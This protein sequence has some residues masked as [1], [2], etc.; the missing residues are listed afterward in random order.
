MPILKIKTENGTWQDISTASEHA[1]TMNDITDLPASIV[2][3]VEALKDKVGSDS[4]A[5]QVDA[6]LKTIEW[7]TYIHPS[8]HP[9]DMIE[10]LADV[11]TSG[12]YN[13]LTDK[14]SIEGLAT[15]EYVDESIEGLATKEYVDEKVASSG[16]MVEQ[17][18][19]DW[20]ETDVNS[21]AYIKNKPVISGGGSTSVQANWNQMDI[22]QADYI[23]NKPFGESE[24][25][26]DILPTKRYDNFFLNSDFGAFMQQE[27][28]NYEFVV[29]DTYTVIWDNEEYTCI[30]QDVNA[31]L[32]GAIAI[33]NCAL[34]DATGALGL[35]GNNEPFIIAITQDGHGIYVSTRDTS[36]GGSH[37]VCI[38]QKTTTIKQIDKKYLPDD[39]GMN[40]DWLQNDFAQSDYIKNRP[41]Y[42]YDGVAEILP[43]NDFAPFVFDDS[44]GAGL[45]MFHVN[46]EHFSP[47]HTITLGQL[48]TV[49]WDGTPYK[50]VAQDASQLEDGAIGLGNCSML[51][52]YGNNEPFAIA[53]LNGQGA[54]LFAFTDQVEGNSHNVQI[55]RTEK[56]IV[57]E[58]NACFQYD[59]TIERNMTTIPV[60]EDVYKFWSNGDWDEVIVYWDGIEYTCP[61][62][63]AEGVVSDRVGCGDVGYLLGNA[64]AVGAPPFAAYMV[65]N[66]N[67]NGMTVNSIVIVSTIEDVPASEPFY[68][69]VSIYQKS[70]TCKPIE[71]KFLSN[72]PWEKITP[73][74]FGTAQSGTVVVDE[75]TQVVENG[76]VAFA[77]LPSCDVN[78]FFDGA[79]YT[80]YINDSVF[81]FKSRHTKSGIY[82]ALT[83]IDI[84]TG[85]ELFT[86]F[87]NKSLTQDASVLMLAST[88]MMAAMNLNSLNKIKIVLAKDYVKK[89]DTKY[90]PIAYGTELPTTGNEGDVFILLSVEE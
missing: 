3:D 45:Y 69:S 48:Y 86:I 51:G 49:I 13:D 15:K 1:H 46:A 6:A 56:A 77:G 55:A 57:T 52:L 60:S 85:E 37:E 76:S 74:P 83:A 29:G 40:S 25:L 36:V 50:C 72:I 21:P 7:N 23:K 31:V 43:A 70:K 24:I 20:D 58:Q 18:Q 9:A 12:S 75:V 66:E 84:D 16:G 35:L 89:I 14:P 88:D 33:G 41:F 8:T 87:K 38:K 59:E 22:A 34:F 64:P 53:M 27:E 47:D 44:L 11:A 61:Q 42:E 67:E 73:M 90:L 78:A 28:A 19:A 17:V 32:S 82:N 62:K 65:S 80:I 63:L 81:Y 26:E 68:H 2:A 71:S 79:Y 10:G 4:V 30:A 54:V 5:F 39:I